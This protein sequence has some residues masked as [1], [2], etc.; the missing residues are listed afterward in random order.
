MSQNQQEMY[1]K[2]SNQYE[3]VKVEIIQEKQGD[4]E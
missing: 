4:S 2:Q 1:A 3:E